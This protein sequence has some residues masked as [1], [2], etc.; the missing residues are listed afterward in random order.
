MKKQKIHN[1]NMWNTLIS[2]SLICDWFLFIFY[3]Y[4]L[5]DL[6]SIYINE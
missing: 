5:F 2:L 6:L 3:V 1:K 4:F